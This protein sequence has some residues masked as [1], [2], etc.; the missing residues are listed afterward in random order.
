MAGSLAF[1]TL[2]AA[3]PSLAVGLALLSRFPAFARFE[4]ALD[5]HMLRGLMPPQ[6]ARM[7]LANLRHF[8][9]NAHGLTV[10]GSLFLL[11]SAVALMLT[12]DNAL[13]QIWG[14]R[15]AR[16][17]LRRA[18]L[19][20]ALLVLGPPLLGA[21]LWATS[22]VIGAS[23][24]LLGALPPPVAFVLTLG[25]VLLAA[26]WL[27]ALFRFVPHTRVH[28]WHAVA[29]G[30]LGGVALELGKRAFAAWV[31]TI[32]TYRAVYGALAA[33][34]VFMLWIYVSWLVT[35][36]AALVA[37]NLGRRGG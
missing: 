36:A 7:V 29:G 2:L 20:A 16:P 21:S 5:E 37:A 33:L 31:L 34:P 27:A 13:N 19:Y 6:L 9:D 32:P 1:T 23:R 28:W 17:L 18:G 12:V 8:A 14:V 26:A 30:V 24:G 35:L 11:L 25:P 4:Q 22:T 3:V 10:L 15:R